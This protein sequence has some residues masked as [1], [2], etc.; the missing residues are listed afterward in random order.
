MYQGSGFSLTNS[1]KITT[2]EKRIFG[3]K[4]MCIY[5]LENKLLESCSILDFEH[6]EL[7]QPE[8]RAV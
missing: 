3:N 6:F 4:T 7:A 5:R 1:T 8:I 2:P